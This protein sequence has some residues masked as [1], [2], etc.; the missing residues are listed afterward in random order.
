VEFHDNPI[1][2]QPIAACLDP[3][4]ALSRHSRKRHR[5]SKVAVIASPNSATTQKLKDFCLIGMNISFILYLLL[6]YTFS[7]FFLP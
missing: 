6:Q 5:P 2:E 1:S 4:T 7:L 3:K